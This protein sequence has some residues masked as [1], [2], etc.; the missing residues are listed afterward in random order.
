MYKRQGYG[1][2]LQVAQSVP[3][4][5]QIASKDTFR[6]FAGQGNESVSHAMQIVENEAYRPE[7]RFADAVKGLCVYGTKNV[8]PGRLYT[9]E[10]QKTA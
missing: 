1:F 5:A 4:G 10:A 7:K 9:I 3:D 2:A 8:L 6:L